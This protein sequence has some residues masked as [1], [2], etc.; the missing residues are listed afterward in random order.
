MPETL[1]IPYVGHKPVAFVDYENVGKLAKIDFELL[2]QLRT[3]HVK[4]SILVVN[5]ST[6]TRGFV[7]INQARTPILAPYQGAQLD[8]SIV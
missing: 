7:R 4:F 3:S 8:I 1:P 6:S 2:I 5:T